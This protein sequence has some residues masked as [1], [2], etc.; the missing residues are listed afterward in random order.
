VTPQQIHHARIM[1]ECGCTIED[2]A[3]TLGLKL[4]DAIYAAA[5]SLNCNPQEH[6]RVRRIAAAMRLPIPAIHKEHR[7]VDVRTIKRRAA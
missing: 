5:P 3:V 2:A 7:S 4:Y 6:A 1:V